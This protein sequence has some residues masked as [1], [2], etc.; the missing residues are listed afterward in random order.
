MGKRSG[1]A[2]VAPAPLRGYASSV[3]RTTPSPANPSRS[4]NP[5]AR[6]LRDRRGAP[7]KRRPAQSALAFVAALALPL[8]GLAQPAPPAAPSDTL[9]VAWADFTAGILES[10]IVA[11][12]PDPSA[13]LGVW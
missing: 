5:W 10:T 7:L 2:G 4:P 6:A 3:S 11:V 8:L 1:A 9:V 13:K 12:L